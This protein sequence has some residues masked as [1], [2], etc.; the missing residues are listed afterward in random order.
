VA[1]P[2]HWLV[3][4]EPSAYSWDRFVKDGGTA[5]TGVRNFQAR[6]NLKAMRKGDRVLFYHSVTGKSVVG[7]AAVS[8]SAYPDP[9]A[10]KGDWV[11]VDL[12]P[13]KP[14]AAPVSLEEIKKTADLEEIPLLTHTRLSVVPLTEEHYDIIM[15]MAHR[16]GS[17]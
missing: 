16:P 2:N 14:L 8:R 13:V 15:S 10:K 4:Q 17:D 3:K 6:N 1:K 12:K 11:C 5:W 7:V 9:T